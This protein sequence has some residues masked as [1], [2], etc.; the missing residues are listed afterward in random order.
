[1]M[2]KTISDHKKATSFQEIKG[3]N[4][5]HITGYRWFTF[6]PKTLYINKRRE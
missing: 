2:A 3:G 5:H 1:M 4:S 6:A